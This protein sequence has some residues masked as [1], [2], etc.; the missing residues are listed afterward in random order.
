M[1]VVNFSDKEVSYAYEEGK[2]RHY[3]KHE[4]FREKGAVKIK[5]AKTNYESHSIGFLGELAWAKFTDQEVDTS[6]YEVRD[7]GED[8]VG[9]EVKTIT[10]YGEGEPELKIP[11]AEFEKRSSVKNYVLVRANKNNLNAVELL[12]T[13][14]RK[15]FFDKK[16]IKQYKK[17]YPINYV[18]PLSLMNSVKE[19]G[20]LSS[21]S[22]YSDCMPAGV[23][24]PKIK[25]SKNSSRKH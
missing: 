13:I 1:V 15:D 18:V 25:I 16:S 8:F 14:S 12:G 24:L 10:Y 4:S 2:K 21:F 17:N 23:R 6:I 22:T 9:T 3:A 19:D 11:K 5:D 20:F 7:S